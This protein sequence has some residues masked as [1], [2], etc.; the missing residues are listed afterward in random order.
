[1]RIRVTLLA[2]LALFATAPR[3][4]SDALQTGMDTAR[5]A[6]IGPRMQSFADRGV[7]SGTVTL[8][9]RHGQVVHLE[10]TGFQDLETRRPMRTDTIFEIMSMTKPVTAVGIMILVEDGKLALYDPVEKYL[11][12]F[13]GMWVIA[14]RTANTDRPGDR[15]RALQRPS[16]AITIYDLLTHTSGMPEYPPEAMGG[17]GFYSN[18][19]KTLAEAVT[20]FSQQPLEFEPGSKWAYSNTGM[21]TLGRI[22]EVVSG[23]PYERYVDERI[24]Q[25][26]GMVDSFFFPPE[27]KRAR[28][29]SVYDLKNGKL[30]S[31]GDGIYRKGAKYPMPEGGMYSTATD[32]AAFY[33]MMLSGGV[34]K[35]R[36]VLS[37]AAVE[38]MTLVHTG[39]LPVWNSNATGYG[40]G[41]AVMRN[42][43]ATLTLTSLG[44]YGHGGAFGTQGWVD[45]AKDMVGVFMIQRFPGGAEPVHEAFREM[46]NAAVIQ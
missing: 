1:M 30:E 37:K 20:I 26:L 22:I 12:E 5:L 33:Q 2:A 19:N 11:P 18:M 21:A 17:S 46:A 43:N 28:I 41:W 23:Q 8:L 42:P 44:A 45:P 13:R 15:E 38:T 25:P 10:A 9:Q 3:A 7:V 4:S 14:S 27:S 40:L 31:L 35:E 39:S 29:A 36:R 34:Y 16:R 24:L 6:R 32:M